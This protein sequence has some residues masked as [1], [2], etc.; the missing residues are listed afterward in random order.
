MECTRSPHRRDADAVTVS[1]DAGD[2]AGDEMPGL[3]MV[4][5]AEPEGVEVGDGPGA[6]GEDI[7]QDAADAG[8]RALVG[9][10]EGRV[11]VAFHLE[12]GHKAVADVD[13]AGIFTRSA[14]HPGGLGGQTPE[15][16]PRRF[17][18]AMLTPHHREDAQFRL[19][20]RP[21]E[22]FEDAAVFLVR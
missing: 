5:V 21:A 16:F 9:F 14:D 10:D 2:D 18:R 22:N 19:V 17:V 3:R 1:S 4:G 6:H 12:D 15:P 7:A 20:R 8:R 11:V 13:D